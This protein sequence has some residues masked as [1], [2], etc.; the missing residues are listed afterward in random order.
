MQQ[1]RDI[2]EMNANITNLKTLMKNR[3]PVSTAV[4]AAA[5][6]AAVTN[7]DD[8]DGVVKYTRGELGDLIKQHGLKLTTNDTTSEGYFDNLFFMFQIYIAF[9]NALTNTANMSA[10]IIF[11]NLSLKDALSTFLVNVL[12]AV[13]KTFLEKYF[14]NPAPMSRWTVNMTLQNTIE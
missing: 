5:S 6:I 11:G 4:P 3:A 14:S 1:V 7:Y 12:N 10:S 9:I 2:G 13:L 8:E